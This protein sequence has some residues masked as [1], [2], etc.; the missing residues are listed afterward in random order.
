M[1]WQDKQIFV[2]FSDTAA[3]RWQEDE[4]LPPGIRDDMVY[5]VM[6][7]PWIAELRDLDA[8]ADKHRHFKLCFNANGVLD[9]VAVN[10]EVLSE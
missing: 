8:I 2:R 7:S 9:V 5:E 4:K 6:E 10:F 3:F 1:D